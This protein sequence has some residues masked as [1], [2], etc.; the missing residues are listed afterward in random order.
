MFSRSTTFQIA[1]RAKA[2]AQLLRAGQSSAALA[3]LGQLTFKLPPS[4]LEPISA[5]IVRIRVA[6]LTNNPA[7]IEAEAANLLKEAIE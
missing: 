6:A 3:Y 1:N 5:A 2:I 7:A 4:Q